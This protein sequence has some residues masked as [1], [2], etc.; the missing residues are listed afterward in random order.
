MSDLPPEIRAAI[1]L[2]VARAI[3]KRLPAPRES[4]L[5]VKE[6]A[7]R[8]DIHPDTVLRHIHA[9]R[10]RAVGEGKLLR[11]PESA[12]DEFMNRG[13]GNADAQ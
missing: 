6:A 4:Y 13:N 1:D 2:A 11:V 8:L 9:G 3:A 7:A 10:I 12:V 5:R